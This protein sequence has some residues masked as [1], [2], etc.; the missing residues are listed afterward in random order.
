MFS[1]DEDVPLSS[2]QE[3]RRK[4][5]KRDPR[6]VSRPGPTD[7]PASERTPEPTPTERPV[8]RKT[9]PLVDKLPA[10]VLPE[11]SDIKVRPLIIIEHSSVEVK[12]MTTDG[13]LP[14]GSEILLP[15]SPEVTVF[16]TL[17]HVPCHQI[18]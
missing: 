11:G 17:C 7:G 14:I 18:E 4:V 3:D 2:G 13:L 12:R 1:S 5:R 10:A 9:N 15:G 6:A 8:E 16:R